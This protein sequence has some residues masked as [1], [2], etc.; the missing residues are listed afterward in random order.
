MVRAGELH[1]VG[2][3]SVA[4]V[5]ARTALPSPPATLPPLVAHR[6]QISFKTK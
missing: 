6:P 2:V 4:R 5:A 1:A 3:G